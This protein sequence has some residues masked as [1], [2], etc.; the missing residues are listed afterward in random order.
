MQGPSIPYKHLL[1]ASVVAALAGCGGGAAVGPAPTPEPRACLALPEATL[2]AGTY[3]N[4]WLDVNVDGQAQ[5]WLAGYR[6]GIT[7]A[8]NIEPSGNS[9]AVV[10][11]L[12]ADGRLAWDSGGE[13]DT[14]GTD[15]AEAL[16]L[17]PNGTVYVAGRTSGAYP[18]QVNRGQF[19]TF[20]AWREA[21]AADTGW[22]FFQHGNERPQHPRRLRVDA[23]G[24]LV[25]AGYDDEYVPTNYLEALSDP[26]V[27]K[28]RR[29]GAGT[30]ADRLEAVWTH[31]FGT[32][33][34]D[35]LDGLATSISAANGAIYVAG[36][37]TSGSS[38]GMYVRKLDTATG[39]A[40]WTAR[41]T[42][43]A[44]DNVAALRVL[45]DG[46]IVMAGSVFG[47]FQ[48]NA[49]YGQQDAFLARID[50]ADGHLITSRQYGGAG[51]EWVTDLTVDA[52]GNFYLVGE[53]TGAVASGA[54]P[55]GDVDVFVLK[56][57]ASGALVAARQWGRAGDDSAKRV[58]VD[59]CGGV[60]AVGYSARGA[61]RDAA[62]W[63]WKL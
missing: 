10:R 30:A 16:A 47:P 8:S 29:V 61:L 57:D 12:A 13:F 19:D 14:P 7:G 24:D 31:Q 44:F 5:V 45:P 22:F 63:F 11:K 55:Q 42:A 25:L 43:G 62:V 51:S 38:K 32:S 40:L 3:S 49:A 48:G 37:T 17:V 58:A 39:A 54:Q 9:R 6:D 36:T 50:P 34:S 33:A 20:V 35:W 21:P 15:V 56:L 46:T 52:A 28:L 1:A 41:Y 4:E 27:T 18:G 26:F 60:V 53:T 2:D 23:A 59:A